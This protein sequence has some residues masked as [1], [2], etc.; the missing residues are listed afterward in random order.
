ME[1][2]P[3]EPREVI[4]HVTRQL[5][6][7]RVNTAG[8]AQGVQIAAGPK[9]IRR[10]IVV[11][12]DSPERIDTVKVIA[13]HET[14]AP[15]HAE[16]E[17]MF[18]F[19]PASNVPHVHG[20]IVTDVVVIV[21][22]VGVGDRV[23]VKRE[24]RVERLVDQ[25]RILAAEEPEARFVDE[26]RREGRGERGRKALRVSDPVP[27][28]PQA[29]VNRQTVVDEVPP[30]FAIHVVEGGIEVV[31]VGDA[32][33]EPRARQMFDRVGLALKRNPPV[34]RPSPLS[35]L[36]GSGMAPKTV[37]EMNGSSEAGFIPSNRWSTQSRPKAA[38]PLGCTQ[39]N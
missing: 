35:K 7:G 29:R 6:V 34:L 28:R 5:G 27:E 38:K 31:L 19:D 17:L 8:P 12:A 37:P 39:A 3:D 30:D 18:P 22:I 14:L 2:F 21:P 13:I 36:L 23:Q 20:A 9:S 1:D 16:L 10:V 32:V 15:F 11:K 26:R 24:W 33:I 4:D 25:E